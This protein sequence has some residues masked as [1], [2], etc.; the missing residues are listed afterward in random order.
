[1]AIEATPP[2]EPGA[3]DPGLVRTITRVRQELASRGPDDLSTRAVAR[4]LDLHAEYL[5]DLV[6][7]A[8]GEARRSR[9]DSVS[10]VDVTVADARLRIPRQTLWMRVFDLL[11]GVIAGAGLSLLGATW[12]VTPHASSVQWVVASLSTAVG[13][14]MLGTSLS[15]RVR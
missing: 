14:F 2:N 9:S 3:A 12:L 13:V 8:V 15:R 11:G 1:M 10:E 7:G 4:V 6:V 5:E